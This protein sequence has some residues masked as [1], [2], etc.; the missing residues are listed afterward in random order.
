MRKKILGT[1]L[2]K[3]RTDGE[4]QAGQNHQRDQRH[5]PKDAVQPVKKVNH[6]FILLFSFPATVFLQTYPVTSVSSFVFQPNRSPPPEPFVAVPTAVTYRTCHRQLLPD[7][8]QKK[9]S[10]LYHCSI[11]STFM[12]Q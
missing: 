1:D 7:A 4:V 5:A 12:K 3:S 8:G 10:G 9:S 2:E 6:L 11:K